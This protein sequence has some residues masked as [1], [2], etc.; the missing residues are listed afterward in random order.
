VAEQF[1]R[2]SPSE[3]RNFVES[4]HPT[5]RSD[6]LSGYVYEFIERLRITLREGPKPPQRLAHRG[7][8]SFYAQYVPLLSNIAREHGYCLTVHGSMQSDLDLLAVP[9]SENAASAE[10]LAEAIRSFLRGPIVEEDE[11]KSL[12]YA[13]FQNVGKKPHGRR[14]WS[15][16]LDDECRG[17][18]IDL[19]VMP[20]VEMTDA[21]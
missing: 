21:L 9:W 3:L 19:S 16:Y 10:V 2:L 6:G 7:I 15:I 18:Y 17:P 13:V 14:A 8:V 11:E 5:P 20:C 1:E 12:P 4:A